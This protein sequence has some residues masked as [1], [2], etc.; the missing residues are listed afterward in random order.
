MISGHH[1]IIRSTTTL[2]KSN[3][4]TNFIFLKLNGKM[5]TGVIPLLDFTTKT[6]F[7]I[8]SPLYHE[9]NHNIVIN[10]QITFWLKDLKIDNYNIFNIPNMIAYSLAL[11]STNRKILIELLKFII[12]FKCLSVYL[13]SNL[14]IKTLQKTFVD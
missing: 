13:L 5:C 12:Y 1:C 8:W 11:I 3:I 2:N 4:H 6:T 7:A 14:S 9:V 10:F